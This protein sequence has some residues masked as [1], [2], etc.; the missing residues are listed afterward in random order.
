MKSLTTL[1]LEQNC[2]CHYCGT[3]MEHSGTKRATVEHLVDKWSSPKHRK[4][5]DDSNRVAACFTCNNTRGNARNRIARNY[6]QDQIGRR[7]LKM[8]AASTASAQLY[9]M[10]GPVP[11]ELFGVTE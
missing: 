11:Q 10:F 2:K 5:E 7:G 1:V 3:V 6:Y 9:K 8:K 4:I